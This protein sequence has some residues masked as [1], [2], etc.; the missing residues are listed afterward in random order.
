LRDGYAEV[1]RGLHPTAK[2]V[3]RRTGGVWLARDMPGAAARF[4]PCDAGNGGKGL[5]LVD[6]SSN[7]LEPAH[8]DADV[9][10]WFWQLL[11]GAAAADRSALSVESTR[12]EHLA[13]RYVL[14]HELG[15]ALS[16]LAGE[17][18]IDPSGHIEPTAWSGFFDFSWR[19]RVAGDRSVAPA[20][21]NV[22]PSGLG[23]GDWSRLRQTLDVASIWVAPGYR[24]PSRIDAPAS[25]S[26]ADKL[27]LAGF[28]TP[29]A[30][31]APTEDYAELFAHAVLADE[32]KI[33]PD[34]SFQV[35]LPGC[36]PQIVPAPYFSPGVSDKRAYIEEQLSMR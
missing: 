36:Q 19:M 28:V 33:H 27:P 24:P 23:F 25:C 9:P 2:Q 12:R 8:H 14:L 3:L 32:G 29:T 11:G 1:L 31:V 20:Y 30:A 21:Q 26:M 15:H 5:I 16:L 35:T 18:A 17:F 22:V 4:V 10:V 7:S 13:V 6:V 34:D